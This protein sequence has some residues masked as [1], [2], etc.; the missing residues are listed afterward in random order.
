MRYFHHFERDVNNKKDPTTA[1]I[2]EWLH[3]KK[4]TKKWNLHLG[5]TNWIL[6]RMWTRVRNTIEEQTT[7]EDIWRCLLEQKKAFLNS[8]FHKYYTPYTKPKKLRKNA[9]KPQTTKK[10]HSY[11]WKV[12]KALCRE[13][14]WIVPHV[15]EKIENHDALSW[16]IIDPSKIKDRLYWAI[17]WI[18]S[19]EPVSLKDKTKI[20]P[21]LKA[22]L[23]E[24]KI[25]PWE[26]ILWKSTTRKESTPYR[27]IW[28]PNI[29]N[30]W[31]ATLENTSCRILALDDDGAEFFNNSYDA[32]RQ[33]NHILNWIEESIED[34]KMISKRLHA[35][36]RNQIEALEIQSPSSRKKEIFGKINTLIRP[37]RPLLDILKN[38]TL[39]QT[40]YIAWKKQHSINIAGDEWI[41]SDIA[42]FEA[43]QWT[44][45]SIKSKCCTNIIEVI[46]STEWLK[47][48]HGKEA[49]SSLKLII[50]LEDILKRWTPGAF[51]ASLDKAERKIW[52]RSTE[53]QC[54]KKA[55]EE[56]LTLMNKYLE[57][58][59]VHFNETYRKKTEA[60]L[61]P[62]E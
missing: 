16:L 49:N 40:N 36:I 2:N 20:I 59:E 12:Q 18:A 50:N 58:H 8:S 56:H 42:R 15:S 19:D 3:Q 21:A 48:K 51:L 61:I 32:T 57:M 38:Q 9:E 23:K 62:L 6:K 52:E 55:M 53:L 47:T 39:N 28:W 26:K 43:D 37:S 25:F 27:M 5:T 11:F 29:H 7:E 31:G 24:W 14:N 1:Q 44:F 22:F 17:K 46:F 30:K 34:M 13:E 41:L 54:Q 35:T 4:R 60:T 45:D 10:H 33:I